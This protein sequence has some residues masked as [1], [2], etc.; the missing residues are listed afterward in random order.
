[1]NRYCL[2]LSSLVV[3]SIES[4]DLARLTCIQ[5]S[6]ACDPIGYDNWHMQVNGEKL[7]IQHL[8]PE[9]GV[10]FD[11]GA[12]VGSWSECALEVHPKITVKAFEPVPVLYEQIRKRFCGKAFMAYDCAVSDKEAVKDFNYYPTQCEFGGLINRPCL[13]NA[14]HTHPEKLKVTT[15]SLDIF[16]ERESINKIDFL[17]IDTE[18]GEWGVLLG[19][20]KLLD[21]HA[22]TRIQFEYGGTY[23]DAGITLKEVYI[24]LRSKGYSIYR[25]V[26]SGL[27][28]I[29]QWRDKLET[30]RYSNY[31]AVVGGI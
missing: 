24:Y 12:N 6:S 18:G 5:D 27:I 3:I 11:V 2:V 30:F 15:I 23:L 19:A 13:D 31:L 14:F 26:P 28:F 16:C 9:E 7:I 22:I 10:V 4:R 29:P 17:K 25:I 8:I 1:M 20:A 21:K